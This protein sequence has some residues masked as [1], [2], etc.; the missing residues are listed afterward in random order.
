MTMTRES[1]ER[2]ESRLAESGAAQAVVDAPALPPT[3]ANSRLLAGPIGPTMLRLAAPTVVV[4]VVQTLVGVAE[5]YFVS[6]LGTDALAGVALVFPVLMLMVTMAN[7]G[8]GGGVA[9]ALAR[10]LGA[11]RR[12]DADALA[13]HALVLGIAFGVVF[14]AAALAGGPWL[15][16]TMG[17]EGAALAAARDYSNAIFLGAVPLWV[18]ALLSAALRGA[19]NVRAPAVITFAGLV[20]LLPLSLALIFGWGPLPRLG[21]TGAG[22]AVALYYT[23]AALVL[24]GYL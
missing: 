18:T 4:L 13:G 24:L 3:R 17:G 8:I 19:G 16:R 10:T 2:P 12:G 23:G 5:T 6:F 21:V 15:Y 22:V 11:G 1:I 14:M 7:G 20:V 9:A